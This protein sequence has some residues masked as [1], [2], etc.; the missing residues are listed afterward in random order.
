MRWPVFTLLGRYWP[1]PAALALLAAA[2]TSMPAFRPDRCE[3]QARLAGVTLAEERVTHSLVVTSLRQGSAAASDGVTVGDR[4][5]QVNGQ[6]VH[7]LRQLEPALL[8]S[9]GKVFRLPCTMLTGTI[10]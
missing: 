7:S 4:V 3:A 1:L 2:V 8:H 10:R 5:E 6:P 9:V